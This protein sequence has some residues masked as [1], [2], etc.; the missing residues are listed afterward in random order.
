MEVN[1][2][3]GHSYLNEYRYTPKFSVDSFFRLGIVHSSD[4]RGNK[5]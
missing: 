2:E 3:I 5:K 4:L 1:I